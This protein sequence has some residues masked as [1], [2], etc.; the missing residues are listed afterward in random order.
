MFAFSRFRAV[1]ARAQFAA[2]ARS[3]VVININ[4]SV[5][6]REKLS[7]PNV[8]N[9]LLF[10]LCPHKPLISLTHLP[11]LSSRRRRPPQGLKVINWSATWCGPC[12]MVAPLVEQLSE[13]NPEVAFYRIDVDDCADVASEAGVNSMPSRLVV[14]ARLSPF[15]CA[16]EFRLDSSRFGFSQHRS[17]PLHCQRRGRGSADWRQS[18]FPPAEVQ[19]VHRLSQKRFLSSHPAR[20]YA[21]TLSVC[22]SVPPCPRHLAPSPACGNK[23]LLAGQATNAS[24]PTPRP[25]KRIQI[26]RSRITT[27]FVV[28]Y[29]L[30]I[31]S[32][33]AEA[34]APRAHSSR[35]WGW[36]QCSSECEPRSPL[37]GTGNSP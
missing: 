11:M 35:S 19:E 10:G 3:F 1:A 17:F 20:I 9:L 2:P 13:E 33:T 12:K 7:D 32:A 28:K 30:R 21:P 37:D 22:C 24:P 31:L 15:A 6:A 27:C 26:A 23:T 36:F 5:V 29:Q 25:T 8:R 18:R 14:S 34:F 4:D 16:L